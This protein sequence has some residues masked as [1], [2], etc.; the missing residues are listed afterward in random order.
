MSNGDFGP[1][2]PGIRSV[3]PAELRHLATLFRPEN[4]FTPYP[5]AAE[6]AG[7]TGVPPTELTALRPER[8]ALHEL[9]IRVTADFAVPDGSRVGDLGINF[10][11]IV[12]LLLERHLS[13]RMG[14]I[15]AAYDSVRANVR[16]LIDAAFSDALEAA[17]P[18]PS[19]A[20]ARGLLARWLR[21]AAR[22]PDRS[23][24]RGS[25]TPGGSAAA[26]PVGTPPVRAA[27]GAWGPAQIA[28]CDGLA[29]SA[30]DD[31][32]RAAYRALSRVMS[33]TYAA[34]GQAWG[35][36]DMIVEVA[37]N[38]ACNE[39]GSDAIGRLIGPVLLEAARLE[40]QRLLPRQEQPVVINTKGPSASGKSTLRLLQQRLAREIGAD[41]NDFA[42]I[43]PDI[44][45]K[46]LLDYGSLGDA[47]KYAGSFTAEEL[48]IVD[49]KLDRYMARK[50]RRGEMTHLLIDRFRFD[51]FAADSDEAGSNLLTRFGQAV[52]LYFV[53]APPESLVERAWKRGL[54]FGRYK[55]VDD[56]LAHAV[57]AYT[58][59]PD[60]FFTWV[61]RSDKR[62]HFE[63]L[64]NSVRLGQRPRTVAFGDNHTLNVLDVGGTLDVERYGRIN[65]D[66]LGPEQ[67][68]RDRGLLDAA[69]NS[70]FLRRCVQGFRTVN[71]ARQSTGQVYLRIESGVPVAIDRT[72][73][74]AAAA[75]PDTRS[76]LEAVAPGAL[77][78]EVAEAS[79]PVT[80]TQ[81][82]AAPALGEWGNAQSRK[83]Q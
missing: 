50:H 35:T 10:R 2:N 32:S 73:L 59:M 79:E 42:L 55:A 18:A 22:A 47:Y 49:Q 64:D 23:A 62:L 51:S 69:R 34:H 46:Q 3:L 67:L 57:L 37:T 74:A 29:A 11:E 71:F 8:L 7:I 36:R 13:P 16:G 31:Q 14:E 17:M 80:L 21:G 76:A 43:S 54:E 45:R 70:G 28:A 30:E 61:R 19:P 40:A 5:T 60:V 78:G 75:D 24:A 20:P 52:Y 27:A 12:R 65:V 83:S 53:I 66:A 25:A 72:A 41:W 48:Q 44:W 58:G 9:L 15:T 68:Y 82:G 63:F 33:A 38:L 39:C 56:T 26:G 1:W 4:A 81:T 6:L 77:R